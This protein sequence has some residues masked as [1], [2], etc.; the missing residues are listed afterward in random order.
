MACPGS[1]TGISN[2]PEGKLPPCASLTL[3]PRQHLFCS[4]APIQSQLKVA[5]AG[6]GGGRGAAPV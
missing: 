6:S 5:L 4:A 1:D 3:N 2:P